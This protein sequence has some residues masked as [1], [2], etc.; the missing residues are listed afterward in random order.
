MLLDRFGMQWLYG[1]ELP[2]I[3]LAPKQALD[4]FLEAF[5]SHPGHGER[6]S[7]PTVLVHRVFL[8]AI[9]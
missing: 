3:I 1:P 6:L 2:V 8:G 4:N 7:L 9:F 5:W